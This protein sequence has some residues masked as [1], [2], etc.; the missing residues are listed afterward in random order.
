MTTARTGAIAATLTNGEVL[1]AGG[2]GPPPAGDYLAS[3]EL[4]ESAPQA[5]ADPQDFGSETVAQPSSVENV[6]VGNVGAQGLSISDASISGGVNPSD[7]AITSD[8]CASQIVALGQICTIGVRFH[9]VRAWPTLGPAG[10]TR[11]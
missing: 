9:S 3:A 1:V 8:G 10:S 2:V 7:F 4:F 6:V 11:Q 5:I